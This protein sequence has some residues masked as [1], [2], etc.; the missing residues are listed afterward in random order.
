MKTSFLSILCALTL[1]LSA[2]SVTNEVHFNKNYSGNYATTIDFGD[3]IEMAMSFDPS[4]E[5][6]DIMGDALPPETQAQIDEAL[7]GIEGVSNAKYEMTEDYQ[8]V[9][10][11]DFEDIGALNRFFTQ[12]QE[13]MGE[14]GDMMD[15]DMM[16]ALGAFEAPSFTKDGKTITHSANMPFNLSDLAEGDDMMDADMMNMFVGMMDYTIIMS[17]DRK[18]KDV[19]LEGVDLLEQDKRLVKTRVDMENLSDSGSYKIGVKLK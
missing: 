1:I 19:E 7:A 18:V 9:V 11:F 2:C 13:N 16:P 10:S 4:M 8:L 3:V 14:A 17:F 12:I 6:Q 15:E 5:D